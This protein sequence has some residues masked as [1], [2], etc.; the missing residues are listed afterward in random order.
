MK[1][2]VLTPLT[3][4]KPTT[5]YSH[6]VVFEDVIYSA[7]QA[8]HDIDGVVIP[9]EDVSGQI[10]Q[11]LENLKAVLSAGGSELSDILRLTLLVRRADVLPVFWQVAE[12]YFKGNAPA[13]TA[14]VVKG[15][16]GTEY[17]LEVEAIAAR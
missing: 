2:Q 5:Y 17:L 3:V 13:V 6:A 15:L 10:R 11:A 1:R 8:P 16:A 14:A 7:G 4:H 12:D 9:P